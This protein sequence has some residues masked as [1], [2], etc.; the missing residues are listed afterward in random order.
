V[1]KGGYVLLRL[2]TGHWVAEHR[3]LM[4]HYIGRPLASNEI[5]HHVNGVKGDN[6]LD[7]LQL[8]TPAE[9]PSLHRAEMS[10]GIT[11]R[12]ASLPPLARQ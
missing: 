6:R 9:H 4:E 1:T 5:V 10:A 3:W 11:R 2:A 12:R 8:V 7:N